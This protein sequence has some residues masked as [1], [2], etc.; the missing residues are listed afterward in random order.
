MCTH[1]ISYLFLLTQGGR[2]D[3]GSS[4]STVD[5]WFQTF[6]FRTFQKVCSS[7]W[8]HYNTEGS[9][10][11]DVQILLLI[12]VWYGDISNISIESI[13]HIWA[14]LVIIDCLMVQSISHLTITN[15]VITCHNYNRSF[16]RY[17]VIWCDPKTIIDVETWQL[18]GL[19]EIHHSFQQKFE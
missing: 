15:Q 18:F 6:L 13:G 3:T 5:D 19:R 2:L 1:S 7:P 17:C 9:V 4:P 14:P 11:H 10:V 8:T 16:R 12:M